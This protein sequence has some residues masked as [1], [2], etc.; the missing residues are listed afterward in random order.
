MPKNYVYP[1]SL[2]FN[3][4]KHT[5]EKTKECLLCNNPKALNHPPQSLDL[6]PIEH[7]WSILGNEIRKIKI[8]SK[9]EFKRVIKKKLNEISVDT[10]RNLV[11]S[12]I[13]KKA[14]SS[15]NSKGMDYKIL[16]WCY[17][18]YTNIQDHFVKCVNTFF[19]IIV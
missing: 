9:H 7:L 18:F 2:F 8:T 6:N 4:P 13:T 10:T 19:T 5:A 14:E 16:I 3:D 11:H 17:N 15:N 12:I 1:V